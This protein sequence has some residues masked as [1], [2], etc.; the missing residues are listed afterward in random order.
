MSRFKRNGTSQLLQQHMNNINTNE[1]STERTNT[2][3]S[4]ISISACNKDIGIFK[5]IFVE[6]SIMGSVK[7][8]VNIPNINTKEIIHP[9]NL[10]IMVSNGFVIENN[11]NNVQ[12]NSIL[13]KSQIEEL[14]NIKINEILELLK[15][16]KEN[17]IAENQ[18]VCEVKEN[19]KNEISM[20]PNIQIEEVKEI[21]ET[22]LEDKLEEKILEI[23]QQIN[24]NTNEEKNLEDRIDE[25]TLEEKSMKSGEVI[26]RG[27]KNYRKNQEKKTFE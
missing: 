27:R 2:K 11:S 23:K 18:I 1:K 20:Q 25:I 9:D 4:R 13:T 22:K 3:N 19:L 6:N 8:I 16:K 14:I 26:K 17:A 5:N 7:D 10:P 15:D 21:K 12:E 24:D